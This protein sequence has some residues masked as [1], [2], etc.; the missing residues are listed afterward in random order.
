MEVIIGFIVVGILLMLFLTRH[1]AEDDA[2]T[3]MMK[4]RMDSEREFRRPPNEGDLL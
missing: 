2:H 1:P 3:T 4:E